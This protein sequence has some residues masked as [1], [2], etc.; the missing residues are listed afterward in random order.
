MGLKGLFFVS[1]I[2]Q[3]IHTSYLQECCQKKVVREPP[4]YA[5]SYTFVKKF[6]GTKDDNCADSCLY[7]KDTGPAEDQHCFKAVNTGAA[8]IDD[9]CDV[10]FGPTTTKSTGPTSDAPTTAG[11]IN[12]GHTGASASTTA[13]Q[14][15]EGTVPTTGETTTTG[16]STAGPT[17][18]GTTATVPSNTGFTTTGPSTAGS[19][20]TGPS[21]AGSTTAGPTTTGPTNTDPTTTGPSTA[22]FTSSGPTTA[23]P[24]GDDRVLIT[25]GDDILT[26]EIFNP[27]TKTSCSLPQ[28]PEQRSSHSMDKGLVCGGSLTANRKTCV[29]WTPT[30]GT[31]NQSHTL[32]HPRSDHVSWA[33]ASG[34]YLMG[35]QY[36]SMTSEKVNLDGSVEDAFSLK[37][38]IK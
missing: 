29:T 38:A 24:T 5:G 28:L 26:A 33:T 27:V 22:G 25:G 16:P 19:T 18:T 8:T 35:G 37:S 32:R 23:G 31:W 12:A 1:L 11:P 9:Q 15:T 13:G 3:N 7:R 6:D 2:L 10:T 20:T 4:E 17:T 34:V 30:S 14:T 21:T 36:S